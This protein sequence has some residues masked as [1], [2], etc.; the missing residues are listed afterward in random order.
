MLLIRPLLECGCRTLALIDLKRVLV[1]QVR[2][3]L[4]S[5]APNWPYAEC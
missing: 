2:L 1:L 3:H 5:R 4:A